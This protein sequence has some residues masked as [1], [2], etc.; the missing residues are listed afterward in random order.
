[1]RHLL[2]AFATLLLATPA[3]ARTVEDEQSWINITAIGAFG[4]S[5]LLYFA[6]VQPRLSVRNGP[7]QI[8]LRPALGWKFS[9]SFS[10]YGGYARVILPSDTGAGRHEN[11][12]FVQASANLGKIG[13]GSLTSRTRLEHRRLSNGDD[14]GWRLRE[15]LRYTLPI[16]DRPKVPRALVHYEGFVAFNRTDWGARS[17]F[18]QGRAFAGVEVPLTGK[19]TMDLGY[20]NQHIHAAQGLW[21][22]NHIASMTLW[23]RL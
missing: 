15:M 13:G 18:D 6:E 19:T 16:S 10:L 21:R 12:L 8:L 1:M 3:A 5:R 7:Q 4:N 11:R 23:V 2:L 22:V 20:L 9:D 14:T 17:G